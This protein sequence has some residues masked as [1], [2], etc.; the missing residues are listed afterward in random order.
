MKQFRDQIVKHYVERAKNVNAASKQGGWCFSAN[1]LV[2]FTD[3]KIVAEVE[4]PAFRS[5]KL[6]H[7]REVTLP[8]NGSTSNL[9]GIAVLRG[10]QSKFTCAPRQ[11]IP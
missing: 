5:T 11:V 7:S 8:H 6:L 10:T 9:S 2:L 4:I 3:A 1:N